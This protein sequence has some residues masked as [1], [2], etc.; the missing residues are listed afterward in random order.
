MTSAPGGGGS[1]DV[2][3]SGGARPIDGATAPRPIAT[4]AL[5]PHSG[6]SLWALQT[7]AALSAV[8]A[9]VMKLVVRD[10]MLSLAAAGAAVYFAVQYVT[11]QR[12]SAAI[13]RIVVA[14]SVRLVEVSGIE[15]MLGGVLRCRGVGLC[16]ARGWA[17]VA[18]H[19]GLPLFADIDSRLMVVV[20]PRAAPG[21]SEPGSFDE[22]PLTDRGLPFDLDLAG[23][24]AI[25]A[26]AQESIP[27]AARGPTVAQLRATKRPRLPLVAPTTV[28]ELGLWVL[29]TVGFAAIAAGVTWV[30]SIDGGRWAVAGFCALWAVLGTLL[31]MG[32]RS[33]VH[34][35]RVEVVG[36]VLERAGGDV[37]VKWSD[38][39]G[40]RVRILDQRRPLTGI[41]AGAAGAIAGLAAGA[42]VRLTGA[43]VHVAA[44]AAGGRSDN[45][46]V[47]VL[48]ARL[49]LCGLGR[50]GSATKIAVVGKGGRVLGEYDAGANHQFV[51][52][53]AAEFWARGLDVD[54]R[55]R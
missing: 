6:Q 39:R 28:R 43:V 47:S 37:S 46:A 55:W 9:V 45:A 35:F 20:G 48:D 31:F 41:G 26:T 19:D 24:D 4:L 53:A 25:L 17:D 30:A 42:A 27:V 3:G 12:A 15:V 38:A 34:G 18:A 29:V 49:Q 32:W 22:F 21:A 1:D 50:F 36:I 13:R 52:D 33:R 40:L 44:T 11:R 2:T 51:R 14:P 7:G 10:T 54:V 23:I 16:G 5:H 8:A